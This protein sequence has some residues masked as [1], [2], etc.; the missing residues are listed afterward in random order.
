MPLTPWATRFW[1]AAISPASSVPLLPWAKSTFAPGCALSHF[2][3]SDGGAIV[4]M[5]YLIACETNIV[6]GLNGGTAQYST[7]LGD[8]ADDSEPDRLSFTDGND[9]TGNSTTAIENASTATGGIVLLW[10][11]MTYH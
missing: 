2:F 3:M 4:Y 11:S 1:I 7:G 5:G 8:R 6:A 10:A 9:S